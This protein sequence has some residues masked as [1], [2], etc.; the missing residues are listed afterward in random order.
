MHRPVPIRA[1]RALFSA[2]L[3]LAMLISGHTLVSHAQQAAQPGSAIHIPLAFEENEGQAPHAVRYVVHGGNMSVLLTRHSIELVLAH[4]RQVS[5][6]LRLKSF[7]QSP[8]GPRGL[9]VRPRFGTAAQLSHISLTLT[10]MNPHARIA[11]VDRLPGRVNYFIGNNPAQWH[12]NIPTYAGLLYQGVYPGINL[13]LYFD[14]SGLEYDW[15]VAPGVDVGRIRVHVSGAAIGMG[16]KGTLELRRG[17]TI[18]RQGATRTYIARSR[19][20]T[21]SSYRYYG[22]HDFGFH[23]AARAWRHPLVI[24]PTLV[25]ATYLGGGGSEGGYGLTIDSQ[26]NTYVVGDTQSEGFPLANPAQGELRSDPSCQVGLAQDCSEGFVSKISSDGKTLLY[27]TY[28]GGTFDDFAH[29]IAVD[30]AGNAYV[31]GNTLSPDF[32]TVGSSTRYAGGGV[33]GDAYVTKLSPQGNSILFSQ[34]LGGSGDDDGEAIVESSGSIYIAG[35]TASV[36]FP[37]AHAWQSSLGGGSCGAPTTTDTASGPC[38]DAFVTKFSDSGGSPV[39]STYI[40]GANADAGTSIAVSNG[41]AYVVGGTLSGNFPTVHPVQAYGGGT[42]GLSDP[43]PCE[44][45]FLTILAAD[46]SHALASTTLGGSAD[47]IVNDIALGPQGA[48]YLAGTTQS[49]NFPLLHPLKSTLSEDDQ[50]AFVTELDPAASQLLYSSYFGGNDLD[51]AYG[52]AVDYGGDIYLTGST[53]STD[54][55]VRNPIQATLPTQPD[56]SADEAAL[57]TAYVSVLS[58][59]GSQVLYGTYFG[60]DGQATDNVLLPNTLGADIAVDH[61]GN[62]YVVGFTMSDRL[63]IPSSAL[64]GTYGGAFIL[65]IHDAVPPPAIP[66][67]VPTATSTPLPTARP[68]PTSPP[69]HRVKCKKGYKLS[70]GKCVKKKK[71][72]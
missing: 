13:R 45:G 66:T 50:D 20:P 43:G 34:Y 35:S 25:F 40:G 68:A 33:L 41:Q 59:D 55:P 3:L 52:V 69:V 67:V 27:S 36:N 22:P 28:L 61:D 42:C 49:T 18:L 4:N 70:H 51:D 38:S 32:P 10:G 6:Q 24:D 72:H 37:I 39:Y 1:N 29:G 21:A 47:D 9:R 31:T 54:F 8:L 46:G 56:V 71:K 2:T 7:P 15:L 64:Q 16:P 57:Q 65:K 63:P 17:G 14:A 26:G 11:P 48:I 53:Q 60:D 12:A 58:P 23:V 19:Q 44:D 5:A 62:A 30:S